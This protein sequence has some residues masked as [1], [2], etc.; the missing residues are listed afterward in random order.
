MDVNQPSRLRSYSELKLLLSFNATI[1]SRL[2]AEIE[3][4]VQNISLNPLNNDDEAEVLIA[5]QQYDALLN[6]ARRPDGLSARIDRDRRTEMVPLKHG[7]TA[8]VFFTLGNL[9]SFGRYVHRESPTAE[10][11]ARL[12]LA[13]RVAHYTQFLSEVAKSSPQTDVVWDLNSVRESLQFLADERAAASA[14]AAQAAGAIFLKTADDET[15][16]LSLAALSKMNN[17]TA[18]KQLL[19]LYQREPAQ[20]DL[21]ADIAQR[22]RQAVAD[23]TQIK[24][25]EAKLLLSQLGT[26]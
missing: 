22:L 9:F 4:R 5:R 10:L 6:Y 17:K 11:Y 23:D 12:E 14:T 7:P 20:S 24:P 25:K 1:D 15:R 18:R 3:R 8:R 16:R 26:P 2:R 21:R 13:R 19:L